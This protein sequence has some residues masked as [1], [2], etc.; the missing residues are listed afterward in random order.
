MDVEVKSGL[1]LVCSPPCILNMFSFNPTRDKTQQV[2]FKIK[3]Y[4]D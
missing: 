1:V 4:M 3:T 2:A